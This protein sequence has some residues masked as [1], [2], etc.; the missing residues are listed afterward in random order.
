VVNLPPVRVFDN[1]LCPGFVKVAHF[2]DEGVPYVLILDDD[3]SLNSFSGGKRKGNTPE[4]SDEL[5][6][7]RLF[8]SENVNVEIVAGA[9]ELDG[10]A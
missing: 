2:R 6:F 10:L 5:V 7:A 9:Q 8:E 1:E 3:I 4:R